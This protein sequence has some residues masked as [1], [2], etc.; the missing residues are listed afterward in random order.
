MNHI[1]IYTIMIIIIIILASIL[2]YIKVTEEDIACHECKDC[3]TDVYKTISIVPRNFN[4]LRLFLFNHNGDAKFTSLN[5]KNNIQLEYQE[6]SNIPLIIDKNG[7]YLSLENNVNQKQ[8]K[9]SNDEN[10]I[11]ANAEI[12][13][14]NGIK[15]YSD[16][17]GTKYYLQCEQLLS[18][19]VSNVIIK[20]IV[21]SSQSTV[22]SL[23]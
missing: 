6:N 20:N 18:S 17:N 23:L 13:D 16:V 12:V 10:L 21:A 4:N 8:F 3:I 9:F 11:K 22:L 15:I 14:N 19:E 1:V 7:N 2:V 5:I